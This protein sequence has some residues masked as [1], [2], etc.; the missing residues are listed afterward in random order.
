M[1]CAPA[2]PPPLLYRSELQYAPP[3]DEVDLL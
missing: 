3:Q 1:L 2:M